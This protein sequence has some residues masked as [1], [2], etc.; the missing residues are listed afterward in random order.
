MRRLGD[1]RQTCARREVAGQQRR[2]RRHA[3]VSSGRM[4]SGAGP[5]SASRLG[6]QEA[7]SMSALPTHALFQSTS[8]ARPSRRQ[9]LSLRTSKCR[10]DVP[11]ISAV[12]DAADERGEVVEEPLRRAEPE[13]EEGLP[14]R[15]PRPASRPGRTGSRRPEARPRAAASACTDR[16]GREDRVDAERRPTAEATSHP[17]DPRG[18]A[19]GRARRR[20]SR[21]AAGGRLPVERLVDAVLLAQPLRRVVEGGDLHE[22]GPSRPRG[23]RRTADWTGRRAR[24]RHA[25][26]P[27]SHPSARRTRSMSAASGCTSPRLSMSCRGPVGSIAE[28]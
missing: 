6:S 22:R 7:V 20:P 17:T 3:G 10:K 19:P 15:R 5:P 16:E 8:T 11:P 25:R 23:R 2:D 21:A 1:R 4:S 24:T 18:R 13:R 12:A 26:R 9:R 28:T 27:A 14:G